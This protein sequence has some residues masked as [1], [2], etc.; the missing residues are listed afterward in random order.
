M[1]RRTSSE[2]HV[3]HVLNRSV[4]RERLF[5]D[6][7]DYRTFERLLSEA[8][9]RIPTRLL[10]YCIMPNHWHLV[11]WPYATELPRFMHWLTLTHATRWH[12][13]KGSRG[14]GHVYQNRYNAI[15]VQTEGH[16]LTL[17]RY[18]ERNAATAGLVERAEDWRWCSLWRRCNF[19]DDLP[20][21][22]WPISQPE[23]WISL[24]NQPQ[25]ARELSAIHTA[26]RHQRPFGEA[27]WA[28]DLAAKPS[29]PVRGRDRV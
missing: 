10:A 8:L 3:V 11:L 17:L 27:T 5:F 23:G 13:A 6:A 15:P 28:A 14:T 26:V 19:C 1:P 29:R 7:N 24:V 4:R 21:A 18:V 20:L 16:L 22:S 2:G 9:V 25:T 12:L